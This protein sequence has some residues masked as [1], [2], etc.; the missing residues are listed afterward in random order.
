[1]PQTKPEKLYD[2][3]ALEELLCLSRYTIR[4]KILKGE[5]GETINNGRQHLVTESGL[6]AWYEA[7]KGPPVGYVRHLGGGTPKMKKK[8]VQR[9]TMKDIE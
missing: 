3:A 2:I 7:R 5:F 6:I 1:M 9:L 8:P 4:Q